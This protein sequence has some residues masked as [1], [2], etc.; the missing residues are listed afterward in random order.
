MNPALI[1]LF[2]FLAVV[3]LFVLRTPVAFTLGTVGIVSLYLINGPRFLQMLP[4]SIIESM[5]SI[6]LLAIPLFIFIG[7]ILEK[8]GIAD[9]IFEMIYKW[10][11]PIPGGLAIGTVFICVVF[12]A[13]VGIVGAATVTMGLIALPA[14][15]KRGYKPSLA[16][17]CISGGGALGF[18]IPPSVTMIVYASLSNLSIGKMFL[19]GIIPGLLLASLFITY[20]LIRSLINPELAP[21]IPVEERATWKEKWMSVKNLAMPFI[22]IFSIMGTIFSGLATPTEAAAVGAVVAMVIVSLRSKSFKD[23]I[24]V[25]SNAAE[26]AAFLTSM[27]LW[28]II[29]CLAFSAVVNTLGLPMLLKD[30][31]DSIG[32]NRWS[33]LI[34]MQISFFLLGMVM[35][36]L[37][38]IMITVPIYVPLIT[39]LGFNPLWFGIL[40]IVNMQMAYLTPPF[41]FVLFYMKGVVPPNISMGDIYKSV[42]PFIG[43][44]T[45]CLI[46]I[47]VFPEVVLWLP[48]LVGM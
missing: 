5:T 16:I 40:F 12:A 3:I 27:V 31:I 4:P 45:L 43:L 17:G 13:M 9:E 25:V 2:M 8:S 44:Q 29:G 1:V 6:I 28:I 42:W 10:L 47:M 46:I 32:L 37:P 11:G 26:K 35:D 14:M 24:G 39:L 34:A 23:T 36:D 21:P 30:L 41:G 38:I 20:I 15:L 22:L 19:A 48:S 18:L 33:V 7:C